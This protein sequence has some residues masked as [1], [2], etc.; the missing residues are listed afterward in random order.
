M[1]PPNRTA[2]KKACT[3]SGGVDS[4]YTV[5]S[6]T[7]QNEPYPGNEL[8][9]ALFV[10]G[11]DIGVHDART[12]TACC[13]AYRKMLA[14]WG[15]ELLTASTNV[16]AFDRPAHWAAAHVTALI[17]VAHLLGQELGQFYIPANDTYAFYPTGTVGVLQEALLSSESLHFVVDGAEMT[18]FDKIKVLADVPESYDLLRVCFAKPDGLQN[19]GECGKCLNTMVALELCGKL[20][21]F[22]TF[23]QPLDPARM[24]YSYLSYAARPIHWSTFKAALAQQRYDLAYNILFKL[25][26]N[27]KRWAG[28]WLR[29]KRGTS[30]GPSM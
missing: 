8:A 19:C 14:G 26:W 12:F 17:G 2:A 21:K 22:R 30:S 1:R 13:E 18:K 10:Q 5:W 15:I 3:F 9:Y 4:F 23:A 16:R 24:R 20:D 28:A 25:A 27:Y 11:F 29:Q 7:A 6:H